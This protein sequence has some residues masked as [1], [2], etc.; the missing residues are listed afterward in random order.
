MVALARE[1]AVLQLGSTTTMQDYFVLAMPEVAK[2]YQSAPGRVHRC[3][4]VLPRALT[5]GAFCYLE[6]LCESHLSCTSRFDYVVSFVQSERTTWWA[7][8]STFH[9]LPL[10]MIRHNRIVLCDWSGQTERLFLS[11]WVYKIPH[12]RDQCKLR[13]TIYLDNMV[14]SGTLQY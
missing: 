1:F 10:N 12:V 6:T 13:S 7:G 8:D 5:R 14:S 3:R 11:Y 9:A 4:P 2:S